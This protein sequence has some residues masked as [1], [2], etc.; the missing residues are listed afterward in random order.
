MR[1]TSYLSNDLQGFWI[2][3][4]HSN[5]PQ[6]KQCERPSCNRKSFCFCRWI[7]LESEK[8]ESMEN[9]S[10]SH[11]SHLGVFSLFC[12]TKNF[13]MELSHLGG[14]KLSTEADSTFHS[15]CNE[16]RWD[17][18][19]GKYFPDEPYMKAQSDGLPYFDRKDRIMHYEIKSRVSRKNSSSWVP[20]F[21]SITH[22]CFI[23][24][25]TL[26][27]DETNCAKKYVHL[28][29]EKTRAKMF[30]I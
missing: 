15:R 10:C 29:L 5:D 14:K 22:M 1:I 9:W 2:F 27:F 25:P 4:Y 20:S 28:S 13:T 8:D 23:T 6:E 21:S 17:I 18:G 3:S 24:I 26:S 7:N 19:S 30:K 12:K 11:L 16:T